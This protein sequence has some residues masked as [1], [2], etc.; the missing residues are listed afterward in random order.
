[1][2]KQCKILTSWLLAFP[3]SCLELALFDFQIPYVLSGESILGHKYYF[4]LTR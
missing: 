1:M 2:F 4:E 3:T